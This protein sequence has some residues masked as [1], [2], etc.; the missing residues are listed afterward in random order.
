MR[1]TGNRIGGSNPSLSA[2]T[3][4]EKEAVSSRA[5]SIVREGPERPFGANRS[6]GKS[7]PFFPGKKLFF[8]GLIPVRPSVL[9]TI[10]WE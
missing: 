5:R 10:C 1:H 8:P 9:L 6:P 7:C 4:Q 3:Y 2:R